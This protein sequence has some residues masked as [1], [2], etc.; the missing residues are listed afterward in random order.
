M[1]KK[2]RPTCDTCL[3]NRHCY[4]LLDASDCAAYKDK[5]RFVELPC[6]IGDYYFADK[7][8]DWFGK[9]DQLFYVTSIVYS[10]DSFAVWGSHA[11][12]EN[13]CEEVLIDWCTFVTKEEARKWLD[14]HGYE[15][16]EPND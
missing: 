11:G 4:D 12:R 9:L 14:E 16:V 1:S 6:Q 8:P 15:E 5:D 2:I 13:Q 10:G 3:Y 7:T